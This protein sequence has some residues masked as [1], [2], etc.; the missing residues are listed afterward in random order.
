MGIRVQDSKQ[1]VPA[2][3]ESL[4][5]PW[6]A[7]FCFA[8]IA[9][10][11]LMPAAMMSI[12]AANLLSRNIYRVFVMRAATDQQQ[13]T[14]AK[15]ASVA[16]LAGALAFSLGL[17][18]HYAIDLQLL[19]GIWILQT[20]PSII[21]G[22]WSNWFDPRALLVGW[23]A[24]IASGTWFAIS[25]GTITSIVILRFA[26]CTSSV[27]IGIAALLLNLLVSIIGSQVIITIGKVQ[28]ST[29]IVKSDFCDM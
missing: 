11:A 26:G 9:L 19:G 23:L 3:L 29:T 22:L 24:S 13:A 6:F 28:R 1:V 15:R 8:A 5:S 14:F 27:Y 20:L 16:V 2:L 4:F 7:G 18:T 12:A 25:K 21:V 10:A 17:P